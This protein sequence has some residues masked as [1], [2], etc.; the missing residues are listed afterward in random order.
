MRFF[1]FKNT[2]GF[3]IKENKESLRISS[4]NPEI[5]FDYIL[6]RRKAPITC[7]LDSIKCDRTLTLVY[8]YNNKNGGDYM[9]Q[10]RKSKIY[11]HHPN[12]NLDYFKVID[13]KEKAYWLGFLFA[14][15]WL[16][17]QARYVRFGVSSDKK[18]ELQIDR[19]AN[20]I[21]FNLKYK[22]YPKHIT[23]KNLVKIRFM[24][25]QFAYNL[26]KLGFII[27]NKK[28]KNIQLPRLSSRELY[29][30][31]LLGYFDGDGK[32]YAARITCGSKKFLLQ[33]KELFDLNNVIAKKFS[34]KTP[35]HGR[36]L[37]GECYEM[38][39][40]RALFREM[41]ENYKFSLPRKRIIK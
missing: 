13:T 28:S 2:E 30:A 12:I 39:L 5:T 21:G 14:D 3:A 10:R 11:I 7:K 8:I 9:N 1:G 22:Y 41:L 38:G 35:I 33:I 27:G 37:H 36:V 20:A 34:G 32:V 24:N 18:D 40:G 17:R 26:V 19:F 23:E 4:K 29:L 31:F 6:N 15:G 25:R 16:S